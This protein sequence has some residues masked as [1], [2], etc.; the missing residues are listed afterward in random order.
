MKIKGWPFELV[1]NMELLGGGSGFGP[2]D[3]D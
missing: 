1:G 2:G 3:P